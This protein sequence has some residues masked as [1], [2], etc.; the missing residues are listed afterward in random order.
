M[1]ENQKVIV[2]RFG[3]PF[4]IHGYIKVIS[5]TDPLENILNYKPWLIEQNSIWQPLK[6]LDYKVHG[7]FILIKIAE[8]DTPEAVRIF[9]N[10]EIAIEKNQLPELKNNE[11][12]WSDLEG[13]KVINVKDEELGIV[14][15]L[16]NTGANDILVVTKNNKEQLIPYIKHVIIEVNLIKKQI[17]VDWELDY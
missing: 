10:K 5:H 12:Y 4:G 14:D 16:I 11:F 8:Y 13:L 9:T 2:G 15:H 3:A 17:I 7:K 6:I 1:E